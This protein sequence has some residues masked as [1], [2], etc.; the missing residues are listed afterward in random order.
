MKEYLERGEEAVAFPRSVVER[1]LD[2][3]RA[4]ADRGAVGK[5][6]DPMTPI[7]TPP[8][9][10]AQAMSQAVPVDVAID[11]GV[12]GHGDLQQL[13]SATDLYR[14]PLLAHAVLDLGE[15]LRR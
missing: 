11:G 4:L 2:G 6:L 7:P 8:L 13:T 12:A 14:A 1:V 5:A 10:Q 15:R 9:G 3:V